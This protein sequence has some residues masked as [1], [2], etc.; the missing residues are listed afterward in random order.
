VHVFRCTKENFKT[1]LDGVEEYMMGGDHKSKA[2]EWV[3]VLVNGHV[4]QKGG[5]ITVG[6]RG[7]LMVE[8]RRGIVPTFG[9]GVSAEEAM[10]ER[11]RRWSVVE[12]M[13]WR[14]VSQEGDYMWSEE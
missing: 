12:K 9:V 10:T 8:S 1:T 4:G 7:W 13:G 14:A 3:G 11:G 5:D 2:R 6:W